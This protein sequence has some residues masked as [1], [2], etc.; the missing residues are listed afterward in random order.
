MTRRGRDVLLDT[1]PL[2]ALFDQGDQWHSACV[3]A[4]DALGPRCVTTE[5]VV[6]EATYM[7]GRGG[8]SPALVLEFLLAAGVEILGLEAEGHRR[9]AALLR[10]YRDIPMDYAD[11]TLV[12]AAEWLGSS[13]V[14]TLDRR[15]FRSYRKGRGAAFTVVPS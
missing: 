4:W 15:G 3:E 7:V 14:F 9:A 13:E 5:A 6:T 12:I 1:G 10:K 2:V 11:A 8:G